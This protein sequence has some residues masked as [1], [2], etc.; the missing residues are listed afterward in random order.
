MRLKICSMDGT[1]NLAKSSRMKRLK[2]KE[3]A[4]RVRRL[5]EEA[6]RFE[7]ALSRTAKPKPKRRRP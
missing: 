2:E 7:E 3:R 5:D 6:K 4:D 1:G